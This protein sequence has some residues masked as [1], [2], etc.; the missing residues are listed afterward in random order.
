MV[1]GGLATSV[2]CVGRDQK[3]LDPTES[4]TGRSLFLAS[5]GGSAPQRTNTESE[6]Q[7]TCFFGGVRYISRALMSGRGPHIL[8]GGLTFGVR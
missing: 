5:F 1:A 4:W 6:H 3:E 8:L 7:F 2:R